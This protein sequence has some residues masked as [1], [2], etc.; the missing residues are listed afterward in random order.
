MHGSEKSELLRSS[1]DGASVERPTHRDV[2][3][4]NGADSSSRR[5]SLR[6]G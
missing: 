3:S 2:S 6:S 4:I 5:A 1:E